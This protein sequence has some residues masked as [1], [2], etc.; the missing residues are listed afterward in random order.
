MAII[1]LSKPYYATY[2]ANGT[3]V[4]Y[5][6]VT[7]M[8]K[9]VSLAIDLDGGDMQK[10]YADNGVA[11]AMSSFAGATLTV[12][13]DELDLTTA[14][15]LFGITMTSNGPVNFSAKNDAP[16]VGFGAVVK[17]VKAGVVKW[18]AVVL[19]K[20]KFQIPNDAAETQ[21]ETISFQTPSLTA[22]VMQDDT[23]D[24]KW[25]IWKEFETET[26]AVSFISTTLS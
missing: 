6:T 1:G 7:Q 25:K 18:L 17:K 9:A 10:L 16:Y 5:G 23:A 21:G 8:A 19:P 26:D 13:I 12:G 11:E 15:A 22:T 3:T 20:V 24:E 2:T 4:T 14:A